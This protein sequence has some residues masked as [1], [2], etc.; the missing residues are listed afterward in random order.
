[1]SAI[2]TTRRRRGASKCHHAS[3]SQPTSKNRDLIRTWQNLAI[4]FDIGTGTKCRIQTR[5][6][7]PG[8]PDDA[9]GRGKPRRRKTRS[10]RA[11]RR[12]PEGPAREPRAGPSA[13][14]GTGS[15]T[16]A[17]AGSRREPE[18]GRAAAEPLTS[19]VAEPLAEPIDAVAAGG[20]SRRR[21]V[22]PRPSSPH[23]QSL[24]TRTCTGEPAT[25]EP[26]PVEP[27]PAEPARAETAM[28]EPALAEPVTD[29]TCSGRTRSGEL[30]DHCECL[31]RLHHANRSR[32]SGRFSNSQRR[33]V[34][35]QGDVG[36]HRI[37]EAG[38]RDLRCPVA[39][40][41]RTPQQACRQTS[42]APARSGR[43]GAETHGKS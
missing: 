17:P 14:P 24:H 8:N 41:L 43:Q 20:P 9:T 33:P 7:R 42:R 26:T 35:R 27:A 38:L 40:D 31:S 1:M 28:A 6:N 34:A 15:T 22:R 11:K 10:A 39:E 30:A 4:W 23:R 2:D 36:S 29:R 3:A 25:T 5:A 21:P 18:G 32:S 12:L 37:R 16:T 13:K 19:R